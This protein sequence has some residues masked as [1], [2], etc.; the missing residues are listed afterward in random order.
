MK[1]LAM[2]FFKLLPL[3][4]RII[5]KSRGDCSDNSRELYDYMM[6]VHLDKKYKMVW[7]V[8]D[9]ESFEK[10]KRQNTTFIEAEPKSILSKLRFH[11][12][13][14]TAKYL[15]SSYSRIGVRLNKGEVHVNLWHGTGPKNPSF[16]DIGTDFDYVLYSSDYFMDGY[17]NS[18]SCKKEQLLPL[19][20]IRND[21]LF[22][23][24]DALEKLLDK[25]YNK[26]VMWMPTFR[27]NKGGHVDFNKD[28]I[29]TFGIPIATDLEDL[30]RINNYFRDENMLLIIK[31]HPAQDMTGINLHTMP[32]ILFLTNEQLY[33]KNIQIYELLSKMDALL[34]DF[35]SVYVD[36]LLL[37][38]PIGFT[39]N[40]A[41]EYKTGYFFENYLDY[42]PGNH[43]WTM[44]DL[45]LYFHEIATSVD[46]FEKERVKING[47]F[48]KYQDGHL[49]QRLVEKLNIL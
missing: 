19:G 22:K 31:I 16:M 9:V 25:K 3:Q 7:A 30:E 23:E 32:H 26:V 17:I 37:N 20:N 21:L 1:R 38:R 41:N 8:D 45:M 46:R 6:S 29:Y 14:A 11:Y 15:F 39:V 5:F 28:I 43:I 10:I 48:N 4:N 44:D 49:A 13:L 2:L 42:M 33:G 36:Y 40:D 35:S 12:N 47:L 24:S 27:K 34:T 18:L